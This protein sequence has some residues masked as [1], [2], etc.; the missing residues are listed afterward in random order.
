MT[1]LTVAN[2]TGSILSSLVAKT[3]T[4]IRIVLNVV[5]CVVCRFQS[6]VSQKRIKECLL[7]LKTLRVLEKK[8]V[9]VRN[10]MIWPDCG[11]AMR[12]KTIDTDGNIFIE[13][14]N[15]DCNNKW[16]DEI[17]IVEVTSE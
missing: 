16:G 11:W 17:W 12:V 5:C 6:N 8:N 14:S 13:C 10:K 15:P 3:T 1:K 9:R 4:P 7:T 2:T